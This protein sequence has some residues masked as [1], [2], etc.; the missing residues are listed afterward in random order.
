M[1]GRFT[2]RA[3]R[4]AAAATLAVGI[5]AGVAYSSSSRSSAT[6]LTACVKANDGAMR[7]VSSAS[8][9]RNNESAVT[10]NA[11]GP[12]G[13]AGPVGPQGPQGPQGP[14][15]DKGDTGDTGATGP[16]GPKGDTGPAGPAGAGLTS[17]DGL[18]GLTCTVGGSAGT[19]AVAVAASG[20]VSVTCASTNPGGGGGGG[21]D[22]STCGAQ[23]N[24]AP[25][26]SWTCNGTVWQLTC[27]AN[28]GDADGQ[29]LDGCEVDLLT[30]VNNCGAVGHVVS[31]PNATAAC[32]NGVGVI[33][34]CNAGF[35]DVDG[36][37]VD[38]CEVQADSFPDTYETAQPVGTLIGGDVVLRTGNILPASDHD[39]FRVAASFFNSVTIGVFGGP[40]FD[41]YDTVVGRVATNVA[42]Y[43]VS[44]NTT[45]VIDVHGNG[46]TVV[47]QYTLHFDGQ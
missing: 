11:E 8:A 35:Y 36:S 4:F 17:I 1:R 23:P 37:P 39:W 13:V 43:Q 44:P 27:N 47:P 33:V 30:D 34:T 7:L 19:I 10:W 38:G 40:L 42:N 5:G 26:S 21:G 18:N 41:V 29:A 16:Q 3:W 20:S 31:L 6:T 46:T 22:S 45:V 24:P 15:G 28:F 14:K 9:C 32:V 25:N 2:R 12:Q